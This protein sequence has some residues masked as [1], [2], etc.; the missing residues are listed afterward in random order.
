MRS[1]KNWKISGTDAVAFDGTT[2][3]PDAIQIVNDAKFHTLTDKMTETASEGGLK[4]ADETDS[5]CVTVPS[6]FVLYGQFTAVKLHSGH[7]IAHR[8]GGE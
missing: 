5:N 3:L 2:G 7:V 6:G 8:T 1:F 4:L